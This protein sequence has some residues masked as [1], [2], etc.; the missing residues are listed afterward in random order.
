MIRYLL[1]FSMIYLSQSFATQPLTPD[2][3]ITHLKTKKS[4]GQTML[5]S[6]QAAYDVYEKYRKNLFFSINP[7]RLVSHTA[8]V[9]NF[10]Q[11]RIG[12]AAVLPPDRQASLHIFLNSNPR[13]NTS[14]GINGNA[15]LVAK[16][17]N[18][19]ECQR[20]GGNDCDLL[21][22]EE[23]DKLRVIDENLAIKSFFR[24][25]QNQIVSDF[26]ALGNGIATALR[27]V[28]RSSTS[29]IINCEVSPPRYDRCVTVDNVVYLKQGDQTI[30]EIERHIRKASEQ[31]DS[32]SNNGSVTPN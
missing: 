23:L 30:S 24:N 17:Y 12:S 14:R 3:F 11:T 16:A 21:N 15:D 1:I 19:N 26:T 10:F 9:Y 8:S 29:H 5:A 20:A 4:R 31:R 28:A 25:A 22:D 7:G 13:F 6:E 27:P 2:E 18:T 32:S